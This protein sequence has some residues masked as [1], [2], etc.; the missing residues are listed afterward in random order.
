MVESYESAQ[1]VLKHPE[2]TKI[3]SGSK[4]SLEAIWVASL[5]GE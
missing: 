3:S 2:S 4:K 1:D 5:A